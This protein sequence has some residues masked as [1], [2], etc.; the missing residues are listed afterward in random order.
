MLLIN[1]GILGG[2]C[3]SK[4]TA[5]KILMEFYWPGFDADVIRFC[6]SCEICQK[7]FPKC[8][9]TRVPLGQMP[10]IY[11]SFKRV[12]VDLVGPIRPVNKHNRYILTLVDYATRY[13]KLL[14]YIT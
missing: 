9:I 4:K 10:L 5:D 1:E 3:G 8:K 2:R 13:D 14:H 7:T 6:R 12:V 11:T